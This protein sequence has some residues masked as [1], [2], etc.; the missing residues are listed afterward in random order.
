MNI[1]KINLF[2]YYSP[3]LN[4]V[5]F[6][7]GYK[8]IKQKEEKAI[9]DSTLDLCASAYEV[10]SFKEEIVDIQGEKYKLT[11]FDEGF[12]ILKGT[13]DDIKATMKTI[14]TK[15]KTEDCDNEFYSNNKGA[16]EISLLFSK[17]KGAGSFMLKEAV[18]RSFE[19]GYEGRVILNA[20]VINEAVGS[21]IPFYYKM[22]F[23]AYDT[24]VQSYIESKMEE[25]KK[26]QTYI[27][28]Q[29]TP[30]YLAPERI[31]DFLD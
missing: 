15:C 18:K 3:A 31:N 30:M 20:M 19:K 12:Y 7:A 8:D 10:P 13:D 6:K 9:F 17:G 25:Y 11:T 27:Q 1:G 28:K 29:G 5:N 4:N 21:P 14:E 23:K 26:T 24:E 22:G 16:I 2:N